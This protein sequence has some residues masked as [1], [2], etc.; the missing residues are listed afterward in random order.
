VS[1]R[2]P[3]KISR[4][5]STPP[6][7]APPS[8]TLWARWSRLGPG[9]QPIITVLAAGATLMVAFSAYYSGVIKA[10]ERIEREKLCNLV[11]YR[12]SA[13]FVGRYV[14]DTLSNKHHG[15]PEALTAAVLKAD[16]TALYSIPLK[17][18]PGNLV[19]YFTELLFDN[20]LTKSFA[21]KINKEDPNDPATALSPTDHQMLKEADER[22]E[23]A[24]NAIDED[25]ARYGVTFETAPNGAK[26]ASAARCQP[27]HGFMAQ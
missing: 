14:V 5:S 11:G 8:D 9:L 21:F 19:G 1:D 26:L 16:D 24:M 13:Y 22:L 27:F 17:D 2:A 12:N 4:T 6:A 3:S 7:A 20:E 18:L 23:R 25:L 10:Q 15:N